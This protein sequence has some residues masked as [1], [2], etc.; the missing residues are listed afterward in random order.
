MQEI[1]YLIHTEGDFEGSNKTPIF[2]RFYFIEQVHPGDKPEMEKCLEEKP[3]R[4]IKTHLPTRF[5]EKTI[6]KKQ[7][8]FVVV[9]RNTKDALASYYNFYKS[10]VFD[11]DKN[12]SWQ[13]FHERFKNNKLVHGSHFDMQL[14][15]WKYRDDPRFL[16]VK[17]ED[18]LDDP[19]KAILQVADHLNKKLSDDLLQKIVERT[20]FK[21][22]KSHPMLNYSTFGGL[23]TADT[24]FIRKGMVG[25]WKNYFSEEQ[26]QYVDK[27]IKE[28]FEP[29]GLFIKDS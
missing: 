7:T 17:Y 27:L 2:D 25:D 6:Q 10:G 3:P 15:W 14:S 4:L 1:V 28:K 19:K 29:E 5:F 18:M 24:P 16:V 20:S 12:G 22:M 11:F 21:F 26:R 23:D 8:K 13:D 9:F